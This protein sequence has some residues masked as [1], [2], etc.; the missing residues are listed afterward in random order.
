MRC[1][2]GLDRERAQLIVQ[3]FISDEI[4]D[5]TP[6]VRLGLFQ[7]Y[8]PAGDPDAIAYRVRML[9]DAAAT[10][11]STPSRWINSANSCA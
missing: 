1:R 3:S 7:G 4:P 9:R 2:K 11:S 6:H 10:S 5:N 8:G